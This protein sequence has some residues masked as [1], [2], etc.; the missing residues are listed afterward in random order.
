M[1]LKISMIRPFSASW[2]AT[3]LASHPLLNFFKLFNSSSRVL[4][5]H[6]VVNSISIGK[7]TNF[8]VWTS[9]YIGVLEQSSVSNHPVPFPLSPA[10]LASNLAFVQRYPYCLP[11]PGMIV[12]GWAVWSTT[13]NLLNLDD[14]LHKPKSYFDRVWICDV[15]QPLCECRYGPSCYL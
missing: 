4:N 7:T 12:K 6:M 11:Q 14:Q 1:H 2:S 3:F 15:W 5:Y 9:L 13:L 10:E 8:T